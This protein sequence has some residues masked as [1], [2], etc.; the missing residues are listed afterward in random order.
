[1]GDAEGL[2]YCVSAFC[3]GVALCASGP[4]I[5]G[6]PL[7]YGVR[8]STWIMWACSRSSEKGTDEPHTPCRCRCP[9]HVA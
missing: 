7:S 9:P 8:G 4:C 3:F 2:S 5:L 1:M 6:K